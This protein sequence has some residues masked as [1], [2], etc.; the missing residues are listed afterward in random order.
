MLTY[1]VIGLDPAPFLPLYGLDDAQL[2]TRGVRRVRVDRRHAFPD[3]V[4][5]RDGEP[6]ET[7]LLVNHVHLE[8]PTAYRSS[9]AIFVR[10]GAERAVQVENRLPE[11]LQRRP[12]SLRAFD[13]EGWMVD[14]A[15]T[16]PGDADAALERLLADPAV[17]YVHAHYAVRGCYAARIERS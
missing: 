9:H 1:Q 14:A 2:Q 12:L 16:A 10:E 6:G 15:L 5:L 17:S 11:L 3:R 4:E 8:V 13:A 7:M